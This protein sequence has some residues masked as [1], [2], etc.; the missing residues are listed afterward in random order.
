MWAFS[1]AILTVAAILVPHMGEMPGEGPGNTGLSKS[2]IESGPWTSDPWPELDRAGMIEAEALVVDSLVSMEGHANAEGNPAKPIRT[3]FLLVHGEQSRNELL[4]AGTVLDRAVQR[5]NTLMEEE[6]DHA[7]FAGRLGLHLSG[8]R[9]RFMMLLAGQLNVYAATGNEVHLHV[10][11]RRT[12]LVAN[13]DAE[14]A[15]LNHQLHRVATH[16]YLHALHSPNRLPAWAN[17]GLATAIAWGGSG[18]E[19]RVDRPEAIAMVREGAMLEELIE[20]D[21]ADG[22]WHGD[23][24]NEAR[25]GLLMERA[26]LARPHELREWILS[27]KKGVEWRRAFKTAFNDSPEAMARW[28]GQYFKVND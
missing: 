25:A 21:Y 5:M 19:E 6:V 1:G 12:I 22:S 13:G 17:E 16:A 11:G 10:S 28:A 4:H 23:R 8:N 18:I 3:R 20:M 9:D 14:P 26:L 27:V 15:L 24:M 7:P 2:Q